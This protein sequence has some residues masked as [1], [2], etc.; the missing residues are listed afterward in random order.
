MGRIQVKCALPNWYTKADL[1]THAQDKQ[2]RK[3]CASRDTCFFLTT[4]FVYQ[5][6]SCP[7]PT[8]QE[9]WGGGGGGMK[10]IKGAVSRILPKL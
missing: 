6:S 10:Q 2:D 9:T 4:L 8:D 3:N 7:D 5:G 1:K